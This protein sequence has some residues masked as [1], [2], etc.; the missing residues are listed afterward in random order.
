MAGDLGAAVSPAARSVA[1]PPGGTVTATTFATVINRTDGALGGCEVELPGRFRQF[2]LDFAWTDP[3]T[4]ALIPG[5]EN[6][7]FSLG[8]RASQSLVLAITG[9]EAFDGVIPPVFECAT[10]TPADSLY[11]INTFE[12]QISDTAPPDI[13]AIGLALPNN[14][15]VIR[16]A[17]EGGRQAMA[18]AAINIGAAASVTVGPVGIYGQNADLPATLSI[19]QSDDQGRCMAAPV[20]QLTVPF[21]SNEVRT[22]SVFAQAWDGSAIPL[23]PANNRVEVQFVADGQLAAAA[24]AAIT[25]P[26]PD[27]QVPARDALRLAQQATFG[28]NQT[29]VDRIRRTGIEAWIDEQLDLR[30]STYQD[31]AN[32]A[33]LTNFCDGVPQPCRRDH[34]SA[35]RLQMRFFDN[36]MNN[37]DQLRQRVAFA[38][39]QILVVS[40]NGIP[41]NYALSRYQQALLDNAFGNYRDILEE[42]S[43]SPTMGVY[44][45]TVNSRAVAPNENFPR[46][47]LQLFALGEVRLNRDGT[48]VLDGE[49]RAMPA[50]TEADV[51]ELSRALTGW[52]YPTPPGFLPSLRNPALFHAD[53]DVFNDEHDFGPKTLFGQGLPAGQGADADLEQAL[54]II[55]N[56]PNVPP[57]ISRQLIQHLVTSN[58]S[59]QY[60]ERIAAVFENNGQGV[61][62]DLRA[63]VRAILLDPEARTYNPDASRSGKLR[64]PVLLMTSVMRLIGANTDGY[65]FLRRL[66]G[67]GQVPFESPSVFNFYPPDF[68]LPGS[69]GLV[70]PSQGLIN[71]SSVF[72]RHN[73]IYDWTYQGK[74]NR[75]DWRPLTSFAGS[76]GTQVDW[77]AWGRL[78]YN[79]D[80]LLDV[81]D[82]YA[83]EED[84]TPTQRSA[85]I[86]AMNADNY[87]GDPLIA[88]QQRAR[89]AVYL[90][91][92]SPQFQLDH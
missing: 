79:P 78:A 68:A 92:T 22:F 65:A 87:W 42:V 54:D 72:E 28:A 41:L 64:E 56:H 57:F 48:P 84:L 3:G 23:S 27:F 58:P 8:P 29:L 73:V 85:I 19:C 4:N 2:D 66:G 52:V 82:E 63:V 16:I 45:D 67:T 6:T 69:D 7:P 13:L 46:E 51:L 83:L 15:G 74:T 31:L 34:F 40:E 24:S 17:S 26:G 39:S 35:F 91:T 33:I 70:S 76:Y 47:L 37:D 25:A 5:S 44:L 75:W 71:M 59:P 43:R 80:R 32:Q 55:F 36:A 1:L 38:L 21:A 89:L 81:L 9:D 88:S 20:P 60:V 30:T 77:S 53:M 86:A 18:V 12:L 61:R 11:G 49:G 10:G 62:G 50:Y 90:I 14:D